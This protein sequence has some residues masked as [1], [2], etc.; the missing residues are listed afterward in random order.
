[1]KRQR[2]EPNSCRVFLIVA[3]VAGLWAGL[4]A[5]EVGEAVDDAV[6]GAVVASWQLRG[7]EESTADTIATKMRRLVMRSSRAQRCFGFIEYEI[8][9]A[10]RLVAPIAI[11][12]GHPNVIT[13]LKSMSGARVSES[14]VGAHGD[15]ESRQGIFGYTYDRWRNF[16]LPA[17]VVVLSPTLARFGS[18]DN[19]EQ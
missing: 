18:A 6:L 8:A 7:P 19:G 5:D 12:S 1:M 17:V 4:C 2:Q 11:A 10:A 9:H 16:A 13:I 14:A 3:S 15:E